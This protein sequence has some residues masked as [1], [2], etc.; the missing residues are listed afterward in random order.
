M[1]IKKF[2]SLYNKDDFAKDNFKSF[3]IW[4]LNSYITFEK[5]KSIKLAELR[6]LS[7]PNIDFYTTKLYEEF[8]IEWDFFSIFQIIIVYSEMGWPL[9][10]KYT[11][12]GVTYFCDE[13]AYSYNTSFSEIH[14]KVQELNNDMEFFYALLILINKVSKN[15]KI[16]TYFISDIYQGIKKFELIDAQQAVEIKESKKVFVA[17]CFNDKYKFARKNIVKAIEECG[18][19]AVLI[20]V[21]EHNSQ[22]VPEIFKEIEESYF[23]VAD[24]SGQRGGVYFEAGYALANNKPLILSCS[25]NEFK[26]VHFDVAQINTI[27]WK[28]ESDLFERLK[29]RI[30]ST[31]G[32]AL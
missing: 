1:N 15:D 12:Q 22:I 17:M 20:D 26:K 27:F 9:D 29:N 2:K 28:D 23:V 31:V 4:A 32:M 6:Q 3:K 8:T 5:Y 19:S 30:D 16:Y 14:Q 18:Y 7:D 13:D 10:E 24:L 11:K 25:Q 21:K